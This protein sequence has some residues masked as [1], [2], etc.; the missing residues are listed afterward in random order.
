MRYTNNFNDNKLNLVVFIEFLQSST[1]WRDLLLFPNRF[2]RNMK[3][4]SDRQ[5]YNRRRAS[6]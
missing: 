2:L 6:R 4:S 1:Q 5:V 3:G